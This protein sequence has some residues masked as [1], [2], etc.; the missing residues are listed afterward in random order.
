MQRIFFTGETALRENVS[1]IFTVRERWKEIDL[2]GDAVEHSLMRE[3]DSIK[4]CQSKMAR[5]L[6][7]VNQQLG[8]NRNCRNQLERDLANKEH[9]INIDS[10]VQQTRNNSRAI[11]THTGIEKVA[12]KT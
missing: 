5:T 10:T 12:D 7:S 11:N 9:S 1:I 4:A 6:E 2:V 3:V 8:L